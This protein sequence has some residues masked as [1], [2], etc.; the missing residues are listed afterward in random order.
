MEILIR[1]P[2]ICPKE[3][4]CTICGGA[5]HTEKWMPISEVLK[6]SKQKPDKVCL[7]CYSVFTPKRTNQ[8]YCPPPAY[9][10]GKESL[11]SARQRMRSYRNKRSGVESK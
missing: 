3:T 4:I 10:R 9:S 8:V 11:C 5:G 6:V 1:E 7:E 2:C